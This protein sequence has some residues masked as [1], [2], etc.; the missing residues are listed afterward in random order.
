MFD[1]GRGRV[2]ATSLRYGWK[3]VRLRFRDCCFV[4]GVYGQQGKC[5]CNH[6]K[7]ICRLTLIIQFEPRVSSDDSHH[8]AIH[9]LVGLETGWHLDVAF[10]PSSLYFSAIELDEA[11]VVR[12]KH[13]TSTTQGSR[14]EIR[15]PK[16]RISLR[17]TGSIETPA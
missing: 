4:E 1:P 11:P 17:G 9:R 6:D 10:S 3:D 8:Q 2:T 15:N 5:L 14:V 7:Q 12:G 16:S 13:M